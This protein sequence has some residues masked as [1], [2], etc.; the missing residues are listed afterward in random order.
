MK[1]GASS[2]PKHLRN[3][4][5]RSQIMSKGGGRK[6]K[7]KL[8]PSWPV[9][10][11]G[12]NAQG[13]CG[14]KPRSPHGAMLS[15]STSG[16]PARLFTPCLRLRGWTLLSFSLQVSGRQ[17][18]RGC[19]TIPAVSA[20]D[21]ANS[22]GTAVAHMGEAGG[23]AGAMAHQKG[24]A[25]DQ[26]ITGAFRDSCPLHSAELRQKDAG[27]L[28]TVYFC[29]E[30]TGNSTQG[31]KYIPG[32]RWHHELMQVLHYW[33][34]MMDWQFTGASGLLYFAVAVTKLRVQSREGVFYQ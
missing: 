28:E 30:E 10:L 25:P 2:M 6:F 4:R 7:P 9:S 24:A 12:Q 26:Y 13:P 27:D 17:S 34:T 31:Y 21:G 16:A 19:G 14:G 8:Q 3:L 22:M 29:H 15:S 18:R 32:F 11:G 1:C 23:S 20:A 5:W 33:F